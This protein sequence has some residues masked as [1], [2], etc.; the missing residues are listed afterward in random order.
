[1]YDFLDR[2]ISE[3]DQGGRCVVWAARSWVNAKSRQVCAANAVVGPFGKYRLLSG[4]QPF[5]RMMALF[6]RYGLENFEFC[7]LPCNHVS[8][9]EALILSLVCSVREDHLSTV[10]QTLG[11]LVEDEAIGELLV[12]LSQFEKALSAAGIS[13]ANPGGRDGFPSLNPGERRGH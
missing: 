1:M 8:E 6:N 7:S 10:N 3:L 13:V 5:L 12:S 9:H 11:L 2:S 4:L